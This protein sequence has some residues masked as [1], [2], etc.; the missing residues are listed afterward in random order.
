M[1]LYRFDANIGRAITDFGSVGL[2]ITPILRPVSAEQMGVMWLTA[3]GF[4]GR[5]EATCSQLFLVVQGEGW[6]EGSDGVRRAIR[7]GQAAWWDADEMHAAGTATGMAA[8][9][10]EG[11]ALEPKWLRLLE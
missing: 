3:D 4:V 9:V 6:V 2:S 11:D 10:I 7:A 8:F 5:H 1:R